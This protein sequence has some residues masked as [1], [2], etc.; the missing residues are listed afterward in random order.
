MLRRTFLEEAIILQSTI[1]LMEGQSLSRG[2]RKIKM[3]FERATNVLMNEQ[4]ANIFGS[5]V[6][7]PGGWPN[8]GM[9]SQE[10][11]YLA[12]A[13]WRGLRGVRGHRPGARIS[14]PRFVVLQR[15]A[16]HGSMTIDGL[17]DP[18][19]TQAEGEGLVSLIERADTGLGRC[20]I[21]SLGSTSFGPGRTLTTEG[22]CRL[23][24]D[25]VPPH[26]AGEIDL[27]G[28]GLSGRSQHSAFSNSRADWRY[29]H[30]LW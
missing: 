22:T 11:A 15:V 7:R 9:Y 27:R 12:E 28:T 3:M 2:E 17:M 23:W 8:G 14:Q 6:P 16:Y 13:I 21:C 26:P 19:M 10:A 5:P 24:N 29:F 25:T 20:R 4:I 1:R 30:G 18:L